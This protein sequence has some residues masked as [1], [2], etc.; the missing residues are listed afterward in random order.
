MS[1]IVVD[2]NIIAKWVLP[3]AD[4]VL[5]RTVFSDTVGR[6]STLVALD[7]ALTEVT[8]AIWKRYRQ[9]IATLAQCREFLEGLLC[10]PVHI[11]PS[12]GLLGPAFEIAAKYDR[13]IYDA[14]FVAL[15]AKLDIVGVT[16]DMPLYNAVKADFPKITLLRE[17]KPVAEGR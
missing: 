6:A 4:S 9:G 3:E 14:L 17:W 1:D 15:A 2:S 16:A 11:E 8:N 5:A 7:F 12:R 10:S 13:S